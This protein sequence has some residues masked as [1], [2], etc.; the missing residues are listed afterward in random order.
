MHCYCLSWP[1]YL[2]HTCNFNVVFTF[3][4]NAQEKIL[5]TV[6]F[7]SSQGSNPKM[8]AESNCRYEVEWVTE[9]ACH[10]DYLESHSCKLSSEQHDMSID[11]TP[12][13]LSCKLSPPQSG[14]KSEP[15][16]WNL[17]ETLAI[18]SLC[19]MAVFIFNDSCDVTAHFL[20][21]VFTASP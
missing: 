11:L 4:Y 15:P 17:V 19:K 12:L 14:D 2:T 13:T 3:F 18:V 9:Y 16:E 10:R 7:V 21:M 8:K 20:C 1:K 6:L 5:S